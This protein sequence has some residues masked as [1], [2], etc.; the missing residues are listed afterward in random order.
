[1][2]YMENIAICLVAPLLIAIF[3]LKGETKRFIGYYGVGILVCLLAAYI[4]S[5]VV[6]IILSNSGQATM[7]TE[8]SV[9]QLTPIVE[10]IMK[11]IP[12]FMYIAIAAP[13]RSSIISVSLAVGLGFAT[14]ENICYITQVGAGDFL[15]TLIRGFSAGVMH[16]VCAAIIGY[17]LSVVYN[18]GRMVFPCAFAI[19]CVTS[20]FHGI[21]NLLVAREGAI[22]IIG[23]VIPLVHATAILFVLMWNGGDTITEKQ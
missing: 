19:L 4:N 6:T 23:F 11:T 17:G 5:Y 10:E 20:T 9:V 13:K 16:T 18:R 3:L 21:Y 2:I 12:V 8:Q 1:M 14:F 15:F 22:R 7:T